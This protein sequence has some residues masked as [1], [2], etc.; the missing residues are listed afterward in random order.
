M[1]NIV[2]KLNCYKHNTNNLILTINQYILIKVTHVI[3]L[4]QTPT[5]SQ[6]RPHVI[7]NIQSK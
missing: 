6:Y 3:F 4:V 7:Y 5:L 2:N 1:L